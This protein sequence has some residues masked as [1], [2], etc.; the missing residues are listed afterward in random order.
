MGIS[1]LEID[2]QL[3]TALPLAIFV[4]IR[5]ATPCWC[6]DSFPLYHSLVTGGY[7]ESPVL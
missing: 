2:V 6:M 3:M 5:N 1:L 7:N 4:F